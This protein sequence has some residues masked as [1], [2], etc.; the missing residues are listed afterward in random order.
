MV[1]TF[2]PDDGIAPLVETCIADSPMVTPCRAF[3]SNNVGSEVFDDAVVFNGL[4]PLSAAG[5]NLVDHCR[6][7]VGQVT[8]PR[9]SDEKSIT[10]LGKRA[11]G[12]AVRPERIEDARMYP[13]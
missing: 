13:L 11:K 6:R 9:G 4:D 5:G 7:G 12:F 3:G 1:D 10:V 8:T 2:F